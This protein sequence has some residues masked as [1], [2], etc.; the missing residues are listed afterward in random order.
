M[1]LIWDPYLEP[2]DHPR[3]SPEKKIKYY[4]ILG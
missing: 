4:L 2:R 3:Y 1:G